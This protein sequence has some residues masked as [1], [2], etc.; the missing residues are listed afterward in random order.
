MKS[1]ERSLK[2][3][4]NNLNLEDSITLDNEI[5]L[6]QFT[7]VFT[8]SLN[9]KIA[10][11]EVIQAFYTNTLEKD[12][13]VDFLDINFIDNFTNEEKDIV[14]NYNFTNEEL[15]KGLNNIIENNLEILKSKATII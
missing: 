14:F 5:D 11:V 9:E 13:L 4:N 15:E 1:L 12:L 3:I 8:I 2:V 7:N 10:K 6:M